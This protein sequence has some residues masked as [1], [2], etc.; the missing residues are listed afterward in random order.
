MRKEEFT[1]DSRDS[2]TK[3][4]AVR[5]IPD[6]EVRFV[7]QLVHGMSEYIE[8][9]DEVATWFAQRGVL[10]TGNDHLGHGKSIRE[11]EPY[12]YFCEQ[13]PATVIVRDVHRLKKL[14]QEQYPS[15]PY[16][17]LGHSMGSFVL[18]NYL[19][20]YGSGIDGAII[21]G[22]AT[23]PKGAVKAGLFLTGLEGLFKGE[24]HVSELLSKIALGDK[25]KIE[26]EHRNDWLCTDYEVV[27]K[28]DAD[29]LCGFTFTV[30]GFKTLF[31]LIDRQNDFGNVI[32]IPKK[33]PIL[34]ISGKEDPIG[35]FGEGVIK[36]KEE[37]LRAQMTDVTMNLY[38]NL[39]HEVLNEPSKEEIYG[40][41]F[42]WINKRI[43]ANRV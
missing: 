42:D 22:T 31:T 43:Q 27:K 18:R 14:T 1:Y 34:I 11:G 19:F 9:Y 37:F 15:V 21:S 2:K 24:K 33:L 3:I 5:W 38:D 30:N 26:P 7:L 36:V 10:V 41:I 16:F 25:S 8:R 29:P 40:Q 4:H 20:K 35:N 12:G 23:Q 17:I 13:D 28:Y 32:K 6:G 39:R